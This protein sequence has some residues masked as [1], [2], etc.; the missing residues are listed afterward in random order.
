MIY[1]VV[2]AWRKNAAGSE[3]V[4][5]QRLTIAIMARFRLSFRRYFILLQQTLLF[6]ILISKFDN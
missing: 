1:S 4:Y 6:A 3:A 5:G 2:T